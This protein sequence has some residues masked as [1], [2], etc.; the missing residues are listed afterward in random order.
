M[1]TL[2]YLLILLLNITLFF[3]KEST[4]HR[5]L[6]LYQLNT[7]LNYDNYTDINILPYYPNIIKFITRFEGGGV[8]YNPTNDDNYGKNLAIKLQKDNYKVLYLKVPKNIKDFFTWFNL[9][10]KN[11]LWW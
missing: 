4:I 9:Q 10:F 7:N 6:Y 2:I 8:L 3:L 11:I 1:S 5:K